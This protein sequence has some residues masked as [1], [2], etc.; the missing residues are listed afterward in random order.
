M[1]GLFLNRALLFRTGGHLCRQGV[2][3]TIPIEETAGR[4]PQGGGRWARQ[5]GGTGHY[6]TAAGRTRGR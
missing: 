2:L 5:Q 3:T 4:N 6:E 1:V